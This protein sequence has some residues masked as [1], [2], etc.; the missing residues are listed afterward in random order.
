MIKRTV[1]CKPQERFCGRQFRWQDNQILECFVCTALVLTLILGAS[2]TALAVN[3]DP[4]DGEGL[5]QPPICNSEVVRYCNDAFDANVRSCNQRRTNAQN[6]IIDQGLA[7]KVCND[8]IISRGGLGQASVVNSTDFGSGFCGTDTDQFGNPVNFCV[9]CQTYVEG[10]SGGGKGKPAPKSGSN[11]CIRIENNGMS[12]PNGN[13]GA[14]NIIS[15]D[16][17]CQDDLLDLQE[18]FQ[19]ARFGFLIRTV[20]SLAGQPASTDVVL[21]AGRSWQPVVNP[22]ALALQAAGVEVQE[23]LTAATI[24]TP[25]HVKLSSG[26][27]WCY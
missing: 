12:V 18:S 1:G 19:D 10:G 8:G 22:A 4:V 25:G 21:C 15:D 9:L 23:A 16:N 11:K 24:H 20:E 14:F 3:G 6:D 7:M 13:W 27:W 26:R 17:I 5:F 2:S